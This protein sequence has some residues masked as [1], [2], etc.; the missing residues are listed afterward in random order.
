[1]ARFRI[2]KACRPDNADVAAG[3]NTRCN[4]PWGPTR[5]TQVRTQLMEYVES[6]GLKTNNELAALRQLVRQTIQNPPSP[7]SPVVSHNPS[8]NPNADPKG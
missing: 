8:P 3:A 2:S 7:S 4:H 5:F 6:S 1:M